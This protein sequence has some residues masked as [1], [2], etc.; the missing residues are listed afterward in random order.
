MRVGQRAVKS[1]KQIAAVEL[2][3]KETLARDEKARAMWHRLN[4]YCGERGFDLQSIGTGSRIE[5]GV[6]RPVGVYSLHLPPPNGGP[7]VI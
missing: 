7:S 2:A 5:A 1:I 3:Q 6:I 4:E